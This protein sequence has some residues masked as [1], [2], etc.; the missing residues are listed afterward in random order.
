MS[1]SARSVR[2]A[3][4]AGAVLSMGPGARAERIDPTF[5]L[6]RAVGAPGGAQ[7]MFRVDAA[8]TGRARAPLPTAPR[9]IWRARVTGG[10]DLPVVVDAR[11]HVVAASP[12]SQLVELDLNGKLSWSLKTGSSAPV[13]G[14][15]ITTNGT[16]LIVTGGAEL[17]G[18][19]ANGTLR[20]RRSLPVPS[21]RGAVPPLATRDG[22]VVLS[23]VG[24]LLALDASGDVQARATQTDP[25]VTLLEQGGRTLIVTER[26]DVL[27]W[28]PPREPTKLGSFGGRVDEGAALSS[29]NHLTAVVDNERLVDFKLSTKTRHVR[30]VS[31]DRLQGPPAILANGESRIASFSG[32]MLGHDRTGLETARAELE[33]SS[34]TTASVPGMFQPP[35]LVVDEKGRVAFVRPGL[36]AGV[37]LESGE[38]KTAA[39]AACGDPLSLA[40]A[41]PGRFVVACRSGLILMIGQ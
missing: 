12:M 31:T 23:V 33:P 17:W 20:V 15:V 11:G 10:L 35:P 38:Q 3:L 36:D 32:L 21:V 30:A 2:L 6:R 1:N 24:S 41:G 27:E 9:V 29:A 18:V 22:G 4:I 37:V 28:K 34:G 25:V 8:R 7:P 39:G 19:A 13:Q 5:P 40:P 16:R 14:P 26:G